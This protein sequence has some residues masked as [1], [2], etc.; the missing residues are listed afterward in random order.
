M[1]CFPCDFSQAESNVQKA[2]VDA[3][4]TTQQLEETIDEFQKQKLKD[5]QKIFSDFVT[6]EMVFHAKALE[7][8]SSAFQNLDDYDFERD[9]E[10]RG[11]LPNYGNLLDLEHVPK[12]HQPDTYKKILGNNS[13]PS[14][15]SV[16]SPAV[17]NI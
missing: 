2:S 3:S 5:I 8:Y 14:P 15:S 10:V 1:L 17:G 13:E 6:I 4:R 12:T 9:M 7:V 11:F 16:P